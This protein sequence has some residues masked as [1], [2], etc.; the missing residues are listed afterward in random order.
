MPGKSHAANRETVEEAI[1]RHIISMFCLWFLALVSFVPLFLLVLGLVLAWLPRCLA[2]TFSHFL[3]IV[4]SMI[5]GNREICHAMLRQSPTVHN[6][7]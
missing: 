7:M 4:Q 2:V 3:Q 5:K 6:K 1:N